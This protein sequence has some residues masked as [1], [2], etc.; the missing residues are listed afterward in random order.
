M[1]YFVHF[2]LFNLFVSSYYTSGI[3]AHH[4]VPAESPPNEQNPKPPNRVYALCSQD[5]SSVVL[6]NIAAKDANGKSV[7]CYPLSE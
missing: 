2:F 3:E 5:E 6:N 4:Y 7:N 1:K